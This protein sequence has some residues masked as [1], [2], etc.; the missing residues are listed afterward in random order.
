MVN[1]KSARG[2]SRERLSKRAFFTKFKSQFKRGYRKV[3][4]TRASINRDLA[5]DV[6]QL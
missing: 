2:R 3:V 4:V 1:P 5:S 6:Q